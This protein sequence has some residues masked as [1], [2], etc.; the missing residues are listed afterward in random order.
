MWS[1]HKVVRVHRRNFRAKRGHEFGPLPSEIPL[2]V[3]GGQQLETLTEDS[4]T[5]GRRPRARRPF[6]VLVEVFKV[7]AVV[8][9][10]EVRLVLAG[11]E[12]VGAQAS[13]SADHLPELRLRSDD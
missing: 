3:H 8:E 2:A 6:G 5:Q 10:I 9:D 1:D 13:A 7:L 4:C 12:E 11:T